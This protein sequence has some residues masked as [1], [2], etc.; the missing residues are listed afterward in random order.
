M[1]FVMLSFLIFPDIFLIMLFY[2][3]NFDL[4][5]D[6][7]KDQKLNFGDDIASAVRAAKKKV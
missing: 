3:F 7:A 5:Y 4:A 6:L 2:C 1:C